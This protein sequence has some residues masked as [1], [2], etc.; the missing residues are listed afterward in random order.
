MKYESLYNIYVD[1][2]KLMASEQG[3]WQEFLKYAG[4][5]YRYKFSTL[6][7]AYAQ[8]PQFT[9]LVSYEDWRR[10]GCYIRKGEKSIPVL[11]DNHY[12]M[13]HMFD[14]TQLEKQS[15]LKNWEVT[16]QDLESFK[17]VFV[18]KNMNLGNESLKSFDDIMA[19]RILN[20][21]NTMYDKTKY[22]ALLENAKLIYQSID[23]IVSE[24]C[25]L[26]HKDTIPKFETLSHE[27]MTAVGWCTMTVARGI[28]LDSKEIVNE[29]R[30]ERVGQH[31]DELQREGGNL[32]RSG[33]GG[34]GQTQYQATEQIR[35]NSKTILGK[36]PGIGTG[37]TDNSWRN[38]SKDERAGRGVKGDNIS[39]SDTIAER[40]SSDDA[41]GAT[42]DGREESNPE[43]AT[44]VINEKEVESED[45]ASFF[46]IKYFPIDEKLAKAAH[47]LMSFSEYVPDSKTNGYKTLVNEVYAIAEKIAERKPE[48]TER[49]Y[50]L[51]ARYSKK[52]ADNVNKESRIG[53]M[54]PSVLISGAGNFPVK[55]KE[56]QIA[57]AEKNF[58]ER[59]EIEEIREKLLRI[60]NGQEIIKAD[61]KNAI[62][63]LEEKLASLQKKQEDMKAVNAYYRKN[64]TLEGCPGISSE[65]ADEFMKDTTPCKKPFSSYQLTNN[66][67]NIHRVKNRIEQLKQAKA[68]DSSEETLKYFK[69]IRNSELMR[70]QLIFEDKPN[71]E[72]RSLLKH[73]GFKWSPKNGAWQRQLTNNAEYSLKKIIE[74]LDKQRREVVAEKVVREVKAMMESGIDNECE[75]E[76]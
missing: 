34:E 35:T 62:S 36:E 74:E 51:A 68:V 45:S 48:E 20:D 37:R 24:R 43:S 50:K 56:K 65:V 39:V 33:G 55:K 10:L 12:R 17:S 1:T 9:Q 69:V 63:K 41:R 53:C 31:R 8:N 4:N 61:D 15:S 40:K 11:M 16:N 72:L 52:L 76:M 57:A 46:S 5:M 21:L 64:K 13:S 18:K 26:P 42:S 7:T 49:A 27:Q 25:N 70:L 71:D 44:T 29:I 73:N 23:F 58:R 67:Q 19:A 60:L 47:V 66:N 59:E 3:Y 28:L 2:V 38:G 22:N 54:C 14:I 32:V 6:V 30:R 75:L